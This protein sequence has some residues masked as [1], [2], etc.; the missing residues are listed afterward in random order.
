MLVVVVDTNVWV[1]A[2]LSP[3]GTPAKLLHAFA[4]GMLQLIYCAEIEAEYRDVLYRP[5]L[6]ISHELLAEFMEMLADS[7]YKVSPLDFD[8]KAL[9]DLSDAPF[10]ASALAAKCPVITGNRKHFPPEIGVEILS[11]VE[12]LSRLQAP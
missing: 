2:F 8:I 12:A 11:P 1:S 5:R 9:P 4:Q 7:G 10:I 3:H 6:N